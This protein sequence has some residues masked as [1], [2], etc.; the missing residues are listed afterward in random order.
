MNY[1]K[2]SIAIITILIETTACNK[3]LNVQP[4][5]NVTPANIQSSSDVESVLFGAYSG[6]QAPGCF[7]ESFIFCPDLIASDSMVDFVGTFYSYLAVQQKIQVATNTMTGNIWTTAYSTINIANTVLD[8][9]SLVDTTDRPTVQGEAYF[10]RGTVFFYLTGIFAKPYSDGNAT[11]NLGIPLVLTPT[12]SYDSSAAGPDK[13][14]RATV[15]ASYA[16]VISDLQ[17]AISL[18]PTS[19]VNFRA[20]V[21]SAHAMLS[22]VYLSMGDYADAAAQADTVIESGNFNLTST[23][24]QTFN[25]DGNSSEDVFA[26]QQSLQS[27]AGTTNNGLATFYLPYS[28]NGT[29]AGGRGDAQVDPLYAD[30][31]EAADFRINY[32]TN[33]T[34]ISGYSGT[35]PN[36]WGAFYK[37]IPVIRLAEMYLTRGEGNLVAGTSIGDVPLN[38]IN[39]VRG[40]SGA[41]LLTTVAQT[42]FIEERFRELGFEGD[43]MWSEKRMQWSISGLSFDDDLLVMPIPQT[44]IDANQNLKQNGGY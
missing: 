26:I 44:D 5:N 8:K 35:Y 38:D 25:T 20:D 1:L 7:G 42:D 22:R 19:N 34:S 6:L 36:K 9:I 10:I 23:Y 4:Q 32:M 3:D 15:A 43:R 33:G 27:N 24:N 11:S 21:Y 30:D 12:Y 31:F 41:S 37:A 29:Q 13:P 40:R 28:V 14:S 16:Q 18:L 39:A 17:T 2:Y